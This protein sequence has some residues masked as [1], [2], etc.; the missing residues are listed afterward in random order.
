[1]DEI[2]N[3][4]FKRM[5]VVI[6]KAGH[7]DHIWPVRLHLTDITKQQEFN[8]FR[9]GHFIPANLVRGNGF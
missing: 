6:A 4:I 8:T 5:V 9:S 7:Y 3:L 2:E 1:L